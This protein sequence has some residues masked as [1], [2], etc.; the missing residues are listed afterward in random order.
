MNIFVTGRDVQDDNCNI[1][2]SVPKDSK[3]IDI[4]VF[5]KP[6]DQITIKTPNN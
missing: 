5:I 4:E 1:A 3:H 2:S 6:I